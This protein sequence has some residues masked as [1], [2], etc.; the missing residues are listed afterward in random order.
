MTNARIVV[1]AM[2]P[3]CGYANHVVD[4]AADGVKT[5]VK[6]AHTLNCAGCN[7]DLAV[8]RIAIKGAELP[9]PPAEE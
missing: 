3:E 2:C 6:E 7:V 1:Q 8:S 5:T 9:P 4:G